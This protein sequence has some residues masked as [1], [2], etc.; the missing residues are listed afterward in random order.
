ML[1][2]P[3]HEPMAIWRRSPGLT[4]DRS[5]SYGRFATYSPLCTA[6]GMD[7]ESRV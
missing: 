2:Q 5:G 6:S 3:D 1:R 4:R 7:W